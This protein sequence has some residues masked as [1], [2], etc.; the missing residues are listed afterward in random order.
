[1]N[2]QTVF[3]LQPESIK[4]TQPADIH[5]VKWKEKEL[6]PKGEPFRIAGPDYVWARWNAE[7]SRLERLP[8]SEGADFCFFTTQRRLSEQLVMVSSKHDV[9]VNGVPALRITMLELK[10]SVVFGPN[11]IYYLNVRVTPHV[12][13][14]T[15]AMLRKKCPICKTRFK[16]GTSVVSCYCGRVYHHETPESHP[17]I[18]EEDL[19]RCFDRVEHC[20]GC[21][22]KLTLEESLLWNAEV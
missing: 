17:D 15:K 16:K 12:G 21:G 20:L 7:E 10:D 4:T 6:E 22:K 2:S 9:L 5:E 18:P 11:R 1:M 14:P 3:E 19:Y 8:S 13:A